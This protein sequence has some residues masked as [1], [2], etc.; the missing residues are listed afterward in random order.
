M[1][2]SSGG[3]TLAVLALSGCH[4]C[5]TLFKKVVITH[6][7]E[8]IDMLTVKR[9]K[10]GLHK[11]KSNRKPWW[12]KGCL[13]QLMMLS[14]SCCLKGGLWRGKV[15][16]E[17]EYVRN[18]LHELA[19]SCA[20]SWA[21]PVLPRTHRCAQAVVLNSCW[22]P[23]TALGASSG[24][25]K[26][27]ATPTDGCSHIWGFTSLPSSSMCVPALGPG[28]CP[29]SFL[30]PRVCSRVGRLQQGWRQPSWRHLSSWAKVKLK[31][32]YGKQ[33][34]CVCWRHFGEI[35]EQCLLSLVAE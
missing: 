21:K 7:V 34:G 4:W 17:G 1:L 10:L 19:P 5:C 25:G 20:C 14:S 6:V 8:K 9:E 28:W 16:G 23:Q 27:P 2:K 33:R 22:A 26:I 35:S 30:E 32:C 3:C 31:H 13:V 29:G 18:F 15:H 11:V 24:S 12:G